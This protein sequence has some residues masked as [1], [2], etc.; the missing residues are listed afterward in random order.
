[1]M[2]S[3]LAI[4]LASGVGLYALAVFGTLF[5][6][7]VLW[8]VESFEPERHKAFMLTV[9]HKDPAALRP[10]L[11]RLMRRHQLEYELRSSSQEEICYEVKLPLER[12]TDRLSNAILALTPEEGTAVEWEEKKVK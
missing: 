11:E 8:I 6:L 2:L 12:R 7:A 5:V 1:V 10:E 4:G 3:A 9:A